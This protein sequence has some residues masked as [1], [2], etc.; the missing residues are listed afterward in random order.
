MLAERVHASKEEEGEMR[1]FLPCA[2]RPSHVHTVSTHALYVLKFSEAQR[3]MTY[4]K[5]WQLVYKEQQST[6]IIGK[7]AKPKDLLTLMPVS[8]HCK[9]QKSSGVQEVPLDTA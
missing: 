1:I 6:I 8:I 9:A 4:N 5:S 3:N 7:K 2:L